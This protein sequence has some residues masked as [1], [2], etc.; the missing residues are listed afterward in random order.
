MPFIFLKGSDIKL[1]LVEGRTFQEVQ[2]YF[3]TGGYTFFKLE[4]GN[5]VY[6]GVGDNLVV[7]KLI[8]FDLAKSFKFSDPINNQ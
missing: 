4:E 8:A 5:Q 7:E 6:Y 2:D 1:Q 3:A